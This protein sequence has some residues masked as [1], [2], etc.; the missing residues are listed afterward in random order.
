MDAP[1]DEP[2][3]HAVRLQQ[4]Q[5]AGVDDG[6]PGGDGALGLTVDHGDVAALPRKADGHGEPGGA[7]ADDQHIG[8]GGKHCDLRRST[9]VGQRVLA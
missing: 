8:G 2:R 1:C 5:G 4:L 6:G 9:L 3:G 7:G